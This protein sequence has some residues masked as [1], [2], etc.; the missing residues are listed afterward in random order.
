[1]INNFQYFDID[2]TINEKRNITGII[3]H[4]K[5]KIV[6]ISDKQINKSTCCVGVGAGYLQDE[7]EGTAHFLEH[8][9]FMGSEKYPESNEYPSYIQTC[10]G[11]FNAFTADNM[12]LY[13]LE[14]DTSFFKKGV[15]MLSWFFK[16][17]ILDMGN[18][19]SEKEIINSEHEKNLLDDMWIMDDI[20]KN[21]IKSGSKYTKFG[22]GNNQSLEGITKEDILKF[23]S[24]YYT[25]NNMYVC[26]IDSKPIETMINEYVV[27][28]NDIDDKLYKSGT[29]SDSRFEKEPLV[30]IKENIIEF[31][32]VSEYNFLNLILKIKCDEKNQ[33]DFQLV[34]LI[35]WLIGT[36]YEKSFYYYLKENNLAKNISSS[37]DY[38]YDYECI[39]CVRLILNDNSVKNVSKILDSFNDYLNKILELGESEFEKLYL[40]FQKVKLLK[41]L[42]PEKNNSVDI[43]IEVIENLIKSPDTNLAI[44]RKNLVP[45]YDSTIFK[46]FVSMIENIDIKITTNIKLNNNNKYIKSK[47]YSTEYSISNYKLKESNDYLYDYQIDNSIGLKN[48]NIKTNILNQTNI[49]INKFPELVF[50]DKNLN[51]QVYLLETNKY[52][53]PV[54][55]ITCFRYNPLIKNKENF[56][57]MMIFKNI[58]DEI[59]NYYLN[60]MSDYKLN[61]S[62][63][64]NSDSVVYNFYGLN[65][66]IKNFI[67]DINKMIN[68]DV[69]FLNENI[70]EYFNKSVRDIKENL[71]NSKYDSPYMLCKDYFDLL[72]NDFMLPNEQI[73]YLEK[74]NF[75]KF[76]ELCINLLKYTREV[77]IIIG[78]ESNNLLLR[79]N[80]LEQD[81]NYLND[82]NIKYIVDSLSLSSKYLIPSDN[83]ISNIKYRIDYTLNKNQINPN[84]LNNCVIK[85]YLVNKIDIEYEPDGFIKFSDV[86]KIIKEKVILDII[87]D[88]I[89]EPLFNQVRTIDKIGYVV[90]CNYDLKNIGN[91]MIYILYYIVQSTSDINSVE[92]SIENFNKFFIKDLKKNKNSYYEKINSL[93]KSKLF[94]FK[95]PF[96]DLSEEVNLYI[97]SFIELIGKFDLYRIIYKICKKIKTKEIYNLLLNYITDSEKGNI[98]LDIKK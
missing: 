88:I 27:F 74:L 55:N 47:W 13:Y 10:G 51:L 67:F 81:Y 57:I 82:E 75:D 66:L 79:E 34:N 26:I 52:D 98:I 78:M 24:K 60:T 5:I 86:E 61:F 92:K 4:N 31:K 89:N 3:L 2:T 77:F 72:L 35:S 25:T 9:L 22:T 17:P 45:N 1:M 76:K 11:S 20:F 21:F 96:G 73:E 41:S 46:K 80:N 48:F 28:F 14:L 59:V 38:F 18:I 23:Y 19:K 69:I 15:E 62:L 95:K 53:N 84:E 8:L 7:Y 16:K 40:N 43:A 33:V 63:I 6:L 97:E 30:L 39:L 64:V 90:K 94:Q 44:V 50:E 65:Y 91:Q 36:E 85:N 29:E 42:Y 12:T 54:A 87:S 71:F 68:P 56:V 32:S 83:K 37:I 93:I 58:C 49:D 70:V